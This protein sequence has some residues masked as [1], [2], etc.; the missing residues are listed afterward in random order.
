[1][2]QLS[3]IVQEPAADD[4]RDLV[5]RFNEV[6]VQRNLS[7]EVLVVC[8]EKQAGHF[9]STFADHVPAVRCVESADMQRLSGT[10]EGEIIVLAESL[11]EVSDSLDQVLEGVEERPESDLLLNRSTLP[12]NLS[13]LL[14]RSVSRLTQLITGVSNPFPSWIAFRREDLPAHLETSAG[15]DPETIVDLIAYVATARHD[16]SS[17][18][19]HVSDRTVSWEKLVQNRRE[20]LRLFRSRYPLI[21]RLVLFCLVGFT[22]VGVDL[23]TFFTTLNAGVNEVA[24][25]A[26]AVWVAMSWN[27]WLNRSVTFRDR[28]TGSIRNQYVRFCLSCLAGAVVNGCLRVWLMGMNWPV[29]SDPLVAALTGIVAGTG[30]NFSFCNLF[31]FRPRMAVQ[32]ENPMPNGVESSIENRR[33]QEL[34]K[35]SIRERLWPMR[36]SA[37]GNGVRKADSAGITLVVAVLI[38]G[39][40]I[41]AGENV[42]SEV[43]ADSD[44]EQSPGDAE[45]PQK[46]ERRDAS[47]KVTAAKEEDKAAPRESVAANSSVKRTP[48]KLDLSSDAIEER[49]KKDCL[50]L[51]SDELEGRGI[52]T[53]GL[54]LAADYIAR[55]FAAAELRDD[56]YEGT[57]F[58]EF[59]LFSMGGDGPIQQLSF[60]A[61]NGNELRLE[62][63]RDFTTLLLSR[64]SDFDL[65]IAFAGYGITAREV[66]YDDFA[67]LNVRG[68]AVVV[69]RHAPPGFE[70]KELI[71]NQYIR[72]KI[73]NASAHGAA[74]VILCTDQKSIEASGSG[75]E[76]LLQAELTLDSEVRPIPVVH[77]R[78]ALLVDLLKDSAGF[79]LPAVE[80]SIVETRKPASA[81]IGR[82]RLN[83]VVS[84][85]R[86]GRKLKNVIAS[87]AGTGVR[88]EQTVIL[89]AHY[90]HLGRGGWGSL[91][92]GANHEIH[93]GAD[94][95]A[96]GTAILMEVARQLSARKTSLQRRVLFIA[97]SAEELGLIG[98]RKYVEDPLVPLRDTV[99]MLNL[100]MVGRLRENRLTVYGTGTSAVWPDLLSSHSTGLKLAIQ[101]RSGGFGPSDHATFY[102]KGI[103]VL[104]FFTG[105]HPQYHRPGDDLEHLNIEGMRRIAALTVKIIV[106]LTETE[107]RP[108]APRGVSVFGSAGRP[109]T[110][111]NAL[112]VNG[113]GRPMLGVIPVARSNGAG[114]GVQQIVP[115]SV[116]DRHGIKKGDIILQLGKREIKTPVDMSE[117]MFE[118]RD[119]KVIRILL[120][121]NGIQLEVQVQL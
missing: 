13:H 38:V 40:W 10:A 106:D 89:G 25:T 41:A 63:L 99:A 52:R 73:A 5:A 42:S 34:E 20:V 83:G 62:R 86:K 116:A 85:T 74:A 114:V 16:G 121:R 43:A 120:I 82:V 69:L 105:F 113:Q 17:A 36:R 11:S 54:D 61:G 28:R 93:N 2:C 94:D 33:D 7:Y 21:Y 15:S 117:A 56:F 58:H 119:E 64:V 24:A 8:S 3:I 68:K 81:S 12:E 110:F 71:Q 76:K 70:R 67:G 30:F 102:E 75:A 118:V 84:L 51:S 50:Y 91:S 22:G 98:S 1:M 37:A 92:L 96:S 101:S 112:A 77:C 100:D 109:I 27:F 14:S 39:G 79:D 60:S 35:H 95:N 45:T 111:D 78:R 31:V 103:P 104:H 88:A 32:N 29:F 87:M 59:E 90:D 6:A 26:L 65:P 44:A 108:T 23:A 4:F 66:Q 97:F 57:P 18:S 47:E 9:Q 46:R 49:L 107:N 53:R 55:E 72:T 48:L 115:K 80:K 19:D